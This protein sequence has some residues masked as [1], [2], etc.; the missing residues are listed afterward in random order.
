M[1]TIVKP[2][3]LQKGDTIALITPSEPVKTDSVAKVKRYLEKNGYKVKTGAHINKA[4]GDY[5]AGTPSERASDFNWAFS[6]PE[7]KAV[8]AVV[9]GMGMS[10]ILEEVIFDVVAQNPKIFVGYSD[11][12]TLQ[13]PILIKT[14]LVTFHGPNALALPDFRQTGYTMS[15]FWRMLTSKDEKI[16]IKPQSVWQEIRP[17]PAEGVLFGGNLSCICKLL[18]TRYDPIAGLEKIY[19]PDQ[20]YLLFWEEDYEQFSEITR[21]LWQLRNTGFFEKVSG[22]IIGKLTAVAEV[23]YQDFPPKKDLVKQATDP[24]NFPVLY[25]VDFG[26]EVPRATIPIGIKAF[27]DTK[28]RRFELLESGVI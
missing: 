14:G 9:G 25:G 16:I 21:N 5:V 3:A 4:I 2:K 26:H 28:D 19:G 17:G 23:D 10:Q 13:L 12:T 24:F 8:F 6:D 18:G 15:N 22:M 7:I 27:M 20:K 1:T 11:M